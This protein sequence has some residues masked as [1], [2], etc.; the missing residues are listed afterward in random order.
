MGQRDRWPAS[1]VALRSVDGFPSKIIVVGQI[2]GIYNSSLLPVILPIDTIA[3]FRRCVTFDGD[4]VKSRRG[5]DS[6][7]HS[8]LPHEW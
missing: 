8:G 3:S 5:S 7:E 2:G 4:T 6:A 1:S